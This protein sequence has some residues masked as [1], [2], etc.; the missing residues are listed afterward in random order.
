MVD[1]SATAKTH[2]KASS[3]VR[4][5]TIALPR[6]L[7]NGKATAGIILVLF[8]VLVGVLA[9]VLTH[10]SPNV[11]TFLP[12]QPPNAVHPLGTTGQGQDVWSQF[13][14]GTRASLIV[15]FAAG[16]LATILAVVIG[17]VSGFV[18]G[19]ADEGLQLL[20][21]VFLVIPGLPLIVVVA[22][23]FPFESS[24]PLIVIIALTSWS[25]GA[26]VLRS[27]VLGMRELP[28]V[29]AARM[30]GERTSALVFREI[31]PNMWSLI[32]SQLLFG[33]IAAV[34][35]EAGLQFIGLGNINVVSWGSMLYWA[36]NNGAL[37]TGA[38]WWFIPPGLAIALF[39][40]GLALI[41]YGLDEVTNPRLRAHR[42][43]ARKRGR[44]A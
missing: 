40:G 20:T 3:V 38:W 8:F 7:N 13:V 5:R 31:M 30:A 35:T 41:N 26:R 16:A 17:M 37:L 34:L 2:S 29:E 6:V 43:R 4:R 14:W 25:W 36:E 9:P 1:P 33:I 32:F 28:F 11:E 42:R 15:G 19:T 39:G 12:L 24:W 22:T 23:Y 18:G 27:Q 10:I 44:N 21:N